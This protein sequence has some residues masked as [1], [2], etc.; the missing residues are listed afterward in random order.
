MIEPI[1]GP[2]PGPVEDLF[3]V[4]DVLGVKQGDAVLLIQAPSE[5][6]VA[7]MIPPRRQ[8]WNIE[9]CLFSSRQ[10]NAGARSNG[11]MRGSHLG[12]RNAT[13]CKPHGMRKRK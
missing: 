1:L 12:N 2:P 4:A 8:R 3:D 7:A 5:P 11:G 6:N 10:C 13:E 9:P